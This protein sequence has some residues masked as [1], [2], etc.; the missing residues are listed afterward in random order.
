[1]EGNEGILDIDVTGFCRFD[2]MSLQNDTCCIISGD[3]IVEV[4]SFIFGQ[5][6]HKCSGVGNKGKAVVRCPDCSDLKERC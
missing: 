6:F 1:L 2:F 3:F 4:S 5:E